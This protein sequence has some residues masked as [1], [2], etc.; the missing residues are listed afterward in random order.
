ML[1]VAVGIA[2]IVVTVGVL[3]LLAWWVL[4]MR[5]TPVKGSPVEPEDAGGR[6]SDE[7]LERLLS[8][9]DRTDDKESR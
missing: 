1:E 8:G 6:L 7:E 9:V 4:R 3:V 2:F 5:T